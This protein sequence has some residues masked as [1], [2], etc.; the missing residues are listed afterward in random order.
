MDLRKK[1]G[2][3]NLGR[4][5]KEKVKERGEGRGRCFCMFLLPLKW[6]L[7]KSRV[8]SFAFHQA[9]LDTRTVWAPIPSCAAGAGLTVTRMADPE[10]QKH[11][12]TGLCVASLLAV[13]IVPPPGTPGTPGHWPQLCCVFSENGRKEAFPA[14]LQCLTPNCARLL[15]FLANSNNLWWLIMYEVSL[16]GPHSSL[17][18]F[19]YTEPS[20]SQGL[21]IKTFFDESQLMTSTMWVLPE[22]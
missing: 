8:C 15:C 21:N 9:L 16:L 19:L 7:F 3:N 18:Q 14:F 6:M 12:R 20:V 10:E 17:P 1:A 22:W 13:T 5:R 2:T 4:E 11:S